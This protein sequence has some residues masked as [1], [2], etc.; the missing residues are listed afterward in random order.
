MLIA[1]IECHPAQS[2]LYELTMMKDKLTPAAAAPLVSS[3]VGCRSDRRSEWPEAVAV[4]LSC[5]G[6]TVLISCMQVWFLST[7]ANTTYEDNDP[8]PS[9]TALDGRKRPKIAILLGFVPSTQSKNGV[10]FT[11]FN[12]LI[13][14]AFYA[15]IWGYD[16]VFNMTDGFS[17]HPRE[18]QHWLPHGTWHWVPH[19]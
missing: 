11:N 7:V 18:H 5:V 15:H 3:H 6:L 14:K 17:D 13:N 4:V 2:V 8:S 1:D 12:D 19:V 10:K 9:S 16:F